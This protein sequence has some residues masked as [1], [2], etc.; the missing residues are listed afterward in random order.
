MIDRQDILAKLAVNRER[1]KSIG[2]RKIG[3]FGSMARGDA[4]ERSDLDFVVDLTPKTFD[5]YMEVKEL[6]EQ[7]FERRVDLVLEGA[8]KPSLRERIG[9]ETVNAAGF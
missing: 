3:L 6:L 7:L 1:L 9:R 2:V 4:T 5:A 8:I